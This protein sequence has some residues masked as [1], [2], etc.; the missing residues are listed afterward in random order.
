MSGLYL[1]G[2]TK[3]RAGIYRRHEKV[4][5]DFIAAAMTGVFCIPVHASFGP[6]N[7]VREITTKS[8]LTAL[9]FENGT[10]DAAEALFDG[11]AV[12]VYVCRL[13]SGGTKATLTLKNRDAASAVT[14]STLYETDLTL[15]VTLKDKLGEDGVKELCVYSGS[16]LMEKFSFLSGG[17]D[18]IDNLIEQLK[19]SAI[20]TATKTDG[21][22]GALAAVSQSALTGG[23]APT[24]TNEDYSNAFTLF[25]TYS[26]NMLVLDTVDNEVKA[27]A[28]AYMD[29][30]H[31]NGSIGVCTLGE[32]CASSMATR[33]S[34]AKSYNAPYIIY[35]G[36]GYVDTAGNKVD[37]YLSVA[38]QA[39]IIG[40]KD[41]AQ[42]IVH[43]QIS[44]AE[45]LMEKLTDAQYIDAIKSGLLLLSEGPEGQV[46]F[47]SGVNTYTVLAE[48][49]DEG[50]KKIKRT[51]VRYEVFDRIDRQLAPLVGKIPCDNEGVNNVIQQAKK[52][53]AVMQQERKILDTYDFY[54]DTENPHAADHAHFIVVIDDVDSLEKIYL[55]YKF[56]YEAL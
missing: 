14:L 37:G 2:E 50:W 51:A 43:T 26:W 23:E 24:V 7:E 10:V 28:K 30:L 1:K 13:G 52:V 34:N 38:V 3:V 55:L 40:S 22:T 48:N 41:S 11:G 45:S 46:W 18:E 33:K 47:D 25:E 6:L 29:R 27:L 9:Y 53:L 21:A 49:D 16:T 4:E 32:S 15:S 5:G 35:C 20:L 54:E 36:S 19:D 39:G 31:D 17:D 42:S 8:A 12:K 56:R 44:D